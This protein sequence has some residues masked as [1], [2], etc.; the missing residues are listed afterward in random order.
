M[1]GYKTAA[2]SLAVLGASMYSTTES[3][4]FM[5]EMPEYNSERNLDE[6]DDLMSDL[7]DMDYSDWDYSDWDV[8]YS[9]D[10]DYSYTYNSE[11]WEDLEDA[12][13]TAI[14][15]IIF[16]WIM[17]PVCCVCCTI[18]AIWGC[19]TGCGGRCGQKGTTT[20]VVAGG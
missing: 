15:V 18:L 2:L 16:V 17:I 9:S 8:D 7:E 10:W 20:V 19:C 11:D 4:S 5:A 13:G 6:W 3:N 12:A 14:A 1:F